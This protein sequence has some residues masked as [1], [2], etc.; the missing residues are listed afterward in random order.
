MQRRLAEWQA[1]TCCICSSPHPVYGF[2]PPLS[3]RQLWA[4]D[5]HHE[6][7]DRELTK[8]SAR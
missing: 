5:D 2:G 6:Q 8:D 7:L 1:R 3:R 4:C